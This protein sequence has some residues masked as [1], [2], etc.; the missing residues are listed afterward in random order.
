MLTTPGGPCGNGPGGGYLAS[1]EYAPGYGGTGPGDRNN[2]SA[3]N[4]KQLS[5]A[6]IKR[7]GL[8][9]EEI[10]ADQVGQ[11]NAGRFD[12]YRDTTTGEWYM[13]PKGGG[14]P[15]RLRIRSFG[16]RWEVVPPDPLAP[17]A[18]G[19]PEPDVPPITDI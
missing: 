10:K 13:L 14:V 16:D 4:L 8:D 11:S 12:I 18:N 5:A 7:L 6:Q 2:P 9:A 3:G 15:I 19:V 17:E 1:C